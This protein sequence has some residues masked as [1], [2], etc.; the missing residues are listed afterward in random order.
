MSEVARPDHEAEHL[1]ALRIDEP[2]PN[3]RARSTHGELQLSD[4]LGQWVL[5]FSHPADFTPVCTSELLAFEREAE[6]FAELNCQL[7]GLSVDSVFAHLAWI[8]DLSTRFGVTVSFPIIE[9]ISMSIATAYGMI[10]PASDTTA[11]VRSVFLIDPEGRLRVMSYY[12][13]YLGRSVD[14]ILRIV[15]AI[16]E[17]DQRNMVAPEGWQPGSDFVLMAPTE[18]EEAVR[19]ENRTG[20]PW[21]Y[22]P[23][24]SNS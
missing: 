22:T 10:H 4:Y 5:L 17:C 18:D 3:F 15:A 13:P 21:Y 7:L 8:R 23:M 19:R 20:E 9:D 2:A 6:Q 1:G 24:G 11:T 12:P 14:E 16:Q